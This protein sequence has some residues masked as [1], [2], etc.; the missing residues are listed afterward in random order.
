MQLQIPLSEITDIF[1][2]P[3]AKKQDGAGNDAAP[4]AK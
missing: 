4:G 1:K 3:N 2:K